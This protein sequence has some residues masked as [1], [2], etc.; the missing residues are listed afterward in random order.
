MLVSSTWRF[1]LSTWWLCICGLWVI[2]I[3]VDLLIERC[4]LCYATEWCYVLL[5]IWYSFVDPCDY[6]SLFS[7]VSFYLEVLSF[8]LVTLYLWTLSYNDKGN[9]RLA[10]RKVII[11]RYIWRNITFEE[12]YMSILFL[13]ELY[14]FEICWFWVILVFIWNLLMSYYARLSFKSLH[15]W[16]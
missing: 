3:I 9:C 1:C 12:L 8:Y 10:Y 13:P 7:L 5:K 14:S 15:V 16:L 11:V 6:L 4:L 2:M